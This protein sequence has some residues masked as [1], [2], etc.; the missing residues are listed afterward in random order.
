M[1]KY[2]FPKNERDATRFRCI[3]LRAYVCVNVGARA[4]VC[5]CTR[6]SK[7]SISNISSIFLS[8]VQFRLCI[9]VHA[10]AYLCVRVRV[11]QLAVCVCVCVFAKFQI[12][13]V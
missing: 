12:R 8:V 7:S 1:M 11:C 6:K 10:S 13:I 4:F 5:V 3:T 2:A 9:D